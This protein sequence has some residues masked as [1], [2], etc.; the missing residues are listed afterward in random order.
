MG[1]VNETQQYI[2]IK[3][4][5]IF[6]FTAE[7]QLYAHARLLGVQQR[8]ALIQTVEGTQEAIAIE[9]M[10]LIM[11]L[12]PQS[13][14][15][16][17]KPR[18]LKVERSKQF[19][20]GFPLE[21]TDIR[22]YN[23]QGVEYAELL[24]EGAVPTSQNFAVSGTGAQVN[25]VTTVTINVP[26]TIE[27]I[28]FTDGSHSVNIYENNNYPSGGTP[29]SPPTQGIDMASYLAEEERREKERLAFIMDY[30]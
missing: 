2:A 1:I 17:D 5:D 13:P 12:Q 29:P 16:L 11:Q 18:P 15:P 3:N 19:A 26:V 30:S 28:E 23:Y 9:S 8:N 6:S 25:S 4:G 27:I 20:I 7:G 24:Y 10:K 21:K 22:A 14:D